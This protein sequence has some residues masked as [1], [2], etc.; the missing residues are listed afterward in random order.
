M[1]W[2]GDRWVCALLIVAVVG[3]GEWQAAGN[4]C[5]V[6]PP[7]STMQDKRDQ[8]ATVRTQRQRPSDVRECQQPQ[9]A[10]SGAEAPSDGRPATQKQ[11]PALDREPLPVQGA[12]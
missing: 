11:Q 9:R 2:W 1:F 8:A 4:V 3:E 7:A 10:R 6:Q 12:P 5:G